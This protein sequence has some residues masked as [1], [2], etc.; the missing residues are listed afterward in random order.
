MVQSRLLDCLTT[1]FSGLLYYFTLLLFFQ[2]VC[3]SSLYRNNKEKVLYYLGF[4]LFIFVIVAS[5]IS[6][7]IGILG[8]LKTTKRNFV[9]RWLRCPLLLAS[10][11]QFKSGH[12]Q[13]LNNIL[14]LLKLIGSTNTK[15]GVNC[16]VQSPGISESSDCF[17]LSSFLFLF[18][19]LFLF[20]FFLILG[21]WSNPMYTKLV[22][23]PEK[24]IKIEN[25]KKNSR[26]RKSDSS[27]TECK[28][29][30]EDN[31][32]HCISYLTF[33]QLTEIENRNTKNVDTRSEQ[34]Q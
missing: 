27:C 31:I 23:T 6:Y 5:K 21:S 14:V 12:R 26:S 34:I 8:V 19:F 32:V 4:I 3:M 30:A 17:L 7:K 15:F 10:P 29:S 20:L 18:Y 2:Y 25:D 28:I 13:I 22:I 1:N 9:W 24:N 33:F 11:K 16:P